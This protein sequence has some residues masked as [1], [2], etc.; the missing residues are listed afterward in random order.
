M[1]GEIFMSLHLTYEKD[2]LPAIAGVAKR[3]QQ[4]YGAGYHAGLWQQNFI[5]DLLWETK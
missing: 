3:L 5:S 1:L 2:M 4:E